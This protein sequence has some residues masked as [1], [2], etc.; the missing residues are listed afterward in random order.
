MTTKKATWKRTPDQARRT[1]HRLAH[2]QEIH[3]QAAIALRAAQLYPT[4][5]RHAARRYCERKGVPVR[6]YYL[7]RQL[8]A[9]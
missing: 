9:V 3:P 4:I 2:L 7:A 5:G 6:L 8:A 1:I